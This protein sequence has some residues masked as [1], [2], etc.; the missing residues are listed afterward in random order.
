M[1]ST[2]TSDPI[3]VTT[4]NTDSANFVQDVEKFEQCFVDE[5]LKNLLMDCADKSFDG[6]RKTCLF[7]E[8]LKKVLPI[9]NGMAQARNKNLKGKSYQIKDN[10]AE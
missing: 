7:E 4:T 10:I 5:M 2:L 1:S 3:D 6:T 8:C 9:C